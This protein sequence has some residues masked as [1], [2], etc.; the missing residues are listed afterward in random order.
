MKEFYRTNTTLQKIKFRV[1]PQ[2]L[3]INIIVVFSLGM[4][5]GMSNN[6]IF[7]EHNNYKEKLV[8]YDIIFFGR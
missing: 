1:T 6:L 5:K 3:N 4:S 2:D 7:R 8:E